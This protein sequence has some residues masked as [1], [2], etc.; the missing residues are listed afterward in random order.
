[1]T[2]NTAQSRIGWQL[3]QGGLDLLE[4]G[5]DFRHILGEP[6]H[7]A[8]GLIRALLSPGSLPIQKDLLRF[9]DDGLVAPI[10]VDLGG[11]VLAAAFLLLALPF[12]Q[13]ATFVLPVF[14]R[15]VK[16]NEDMIAEYWNEY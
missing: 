4:H 14:G 13:V 16:V 15:K 10:G 9:M 3:C 7:L 11:Q 5:L 12:A 2:V 1:M 8:L 6:F